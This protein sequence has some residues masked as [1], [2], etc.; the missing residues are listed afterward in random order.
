MRNSWRIGLREMS[1]ERSIPLFESEVP[2]TARQ[3]VH[4][5]L[6]R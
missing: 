5:R 3:L 2:G 4:P 1:N 6:A